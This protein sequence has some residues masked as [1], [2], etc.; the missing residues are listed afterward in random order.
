M[1]K[2]IRHLVAMDVIKGLREENVSLKEENNKLKEIQNRL[3]KEI[4]SL[5]KRDKR[6]DK[7]HKFLNVKC[8]EY[9]AEQ[10]NLIIDCTVLKAKLKLWKDA[11]S[12]VCT[13][14]LGRPLGSG[15]LCQ[16]CR[17]RCKAMEEK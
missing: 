11:V 12:A 9:Q 8:D 10:D 16:A 13:C 17:V 1:N 15:E 14:D 7:I 6:R 3:R 2:S 5:C 4:E